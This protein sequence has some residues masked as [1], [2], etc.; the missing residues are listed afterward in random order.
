MRGTAHCRPLREGRGPHSRGPAGPGPVARMPVGRRPRT[1]ML[2]PC[3][4]LVAG[5]PQ[6][7][8]R[9]AHGDVCLP[10]VLL[11]RVGMRPVQ[12]RDTGPGT[13]SVCTRTSKESW[14]ACRRPDECHLMGDGPTPQSRRRRHRARCLP[15]CRK[16]PDCASPSCLSCRGRGPRNKG[17]CAVHA[18]CAGPQPAK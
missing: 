9:E 15:G 8:S 18:P 13:R 2:M 6:G 10:K 12:P 1:T 11:Q 14:L 4:L 16:A 7:H 3:R 17:W 5:T